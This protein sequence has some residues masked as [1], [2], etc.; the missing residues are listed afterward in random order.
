MK[1][2]F[3]LL[4]VLFLT[5]AL[6]LTSCGGQNQPSASASFETFS[7]NSASAEQTNNPEPTK[8]ATSP[9]Q[10]SSQSSTDGRIEISEGVSLVNFENESQGIKF[11]DLSNYSYTVPQ[12]TFETGAF[13]QSGKAL[14]MDIAFMQSNGVISMQLEKETGNITDGFKQ[15]KDYSYLRMWVNNKGESDVSIAVVLVVSE[16]LKNGCLNPE[17]AKLITVQG[18]EELVFTSDAADVNLNNGTGDTSLDIPAGFE[19][20]VYY[21]LEGQIP[22]WEGTTLSKE[23]LQNVDTISLDIRFADATLAETII[24]DEL[25]LA[26]PEE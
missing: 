21:P 22:W 13:A 2:Q 16:P 5:A 7:T 23:E 25:C 10:T 19:G 12:I 15:A 3:L 20:W 8:E 24:L 6:S 1:K 26:H 4:T 14:C 17:G 11:F 9:A 18:E